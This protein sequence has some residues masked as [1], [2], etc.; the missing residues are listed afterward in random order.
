MLCYDDSSNVGS[1][2]CPNSCG[3]II[4]GPCIRK[5]VGEE[6]V[7]TLQTNNIGEEIAQREASNRWME[8]RRLKGEIFCAACAVDDD[9][10]RDPATKP[11]PL[12]D[13]LT[14]LDEGQTAVHMQALQR[15]A[16]VEA[17]TRGF[18]KARDVV[19][20]LP[21]GGTVAAS[22][23]LVRAELQATMPNLRQCGQC[24]WGP[25]ELVACFDLA[26]HHGEER[27]GATISNR[28]P[29]CNWFER[30]AEKWPKWSSD[31]ASGDN[32]GFRYNPPAAQVEA[33]PRV[34]QLPDP[35]RP[36]ENE[37]VTAALDRRG[38][39]GEGRDGRHE[40][41]VYHGRRGHG[42]ICMHC[43]ETR[44]AAGYATW[45]FSNEDEL[46]R[47]KAGGCPAGGE[48]H[49]Q[50]RNTRNGMRPPWMCTRCGAVENAER[51]MIQLPN[52]A[53]QWGAPVDVV[54]E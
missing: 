44:N 51:F 8:S 24:S 19:K 52:L 12:V 32:S 34:V 40:W 1:L 20:N 13:L 48:H 18:Q 50:P 49:W 53:G 27:G 37:R 6:D 7:K 2:A 33:G 29:R 11:Y 43:Y 4:C 14:F 17:E 21:G 39:L 26:V 22:D 42:R 10:V 45:W 54:V 35:V 5:H 47:V 36:N 31:D 23:A 16:V 41:V 15:A 3:H 46:A 28:C 38:C 30:D 25:V 9:R